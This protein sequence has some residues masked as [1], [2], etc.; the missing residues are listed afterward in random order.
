MT[1]PVKKVEVGIGDD[2]L[3]LIIAAISPT[4]QSTILSS[5]QRERARWAF[6]EQVVNEWHERY[7]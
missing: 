5:P 3:L 2:L 6:A 1:E 7:H 4:N